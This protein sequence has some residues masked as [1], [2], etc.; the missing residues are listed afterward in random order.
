MKLFNKML[1]ATILLFS[2]QVY[3][4]VVHGG[5]IDKHGAGEYYKW[6]DAEA[7]RGLVFDVK[8]D[9]ILKSVKV[10]NQPGQESDRTFTLY[11]ADGNALDSKLVHLK[12]GKQ[13]VA[14]DFAL[15]KGKGYRLMADIHKGLYKNNEASYPYNIKNIL[16]I[17]GSDID[18]KHYYFFYDWEVE[19]VSEQARLHG[20]KL[21]KRGAGGYYKWDDA[22]A[23]RGLVFD[24]HHDCTLKSVKVYNQPGQ[25][26]DRIFTL[27]DG[28]GNVVD[29]KAIHLKAG[30]QRVALDFAL[31]K[32]KGYRLM[33][34][35]HKGLYKNNEA[36]YPYNIKN[37]LSITGS[38]IDR[39]H[40][41]F[42]Y[43]WEI[44]V[45]KSDVDN[46]PE[47]TPVIDGDVYVPKL[48]FSKQDVYGNGK[49]IKAG[50]ATQLR[51][52]FVNAE[53][54]TTIILKDGRYNNIHIYVPKG[55]HDITIKAEHKGKAVIVPA[56]W[57]DDS[58]IIFARANSKGEEIH[59]INF[60]DIDVDGRNERCQFIKAEGGG[61]Y[62]VHHIYFKGVNAHNISMVLYSGLHSHDWTVDHCEFHSSNLS[63]F[64]YMM[65]WHHTVQNSKIYDGVY[66]ALVVRGYYPDGEQH[67]Y[68]NCSINRRVLS[69]GSRSV[70]NGFLPAND[71]THKI[72]NN[73]FGSW[74]L[75]HLLPR[76]D[77]NKNEG[78][79]IGI[80]YGLYGGDGS[81]DGEKFY[82]PPQN[83]TIAGNTFD[84]RDDTKGLYLDAI[85]VDAWQG[86][87][88]DSLASIN[89]VYV[90]DN[91]FL[92][93]H[94]NEQFIK[95]VSNGDYP[96]TDV[97][98]VD[99]KNNTIK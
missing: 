67:Y 17:T 66:D 46:H 84:N 86:L 11:D 7:I 98:T 25:E 94:N 9:S 4:T 55:K 77:K 74:H 85:T 18:R 23:I 88:N 76:G 24:V 75:Q 73:Q 41:Y 47:P 2:T 5:K 35:I 39:K 58:G 19:S 68:N 83:V 28:K 90:Y 62:S 43:D 97:R 36:S 89:G 30:E 50:T 3:A 20:G 82:L 38:D 61:S 21:D 53:P 10:Y 31:T 80:A 57:D 63:H 99:M 42:F 92:K 96:K 95:G 59:H 78:Y 91:T 8:Q 40:Y 72:I 51:N 16:S 93:K 12:A 71:W 32:G 34:D 6:D 14:L 52:A 13:R 1:F 49:V 29:T 45:K 65:G 60:I 15:T 48:D 69:R 37:I 70:E 81:C 64:W 56:G 22:E 79:H 27:Y 87:N 26:S 33:A 44:E 54:K